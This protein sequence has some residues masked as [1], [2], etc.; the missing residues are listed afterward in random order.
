MIVE[1]LL[2]ILTILEFPDERLRKKAAPVETVDADIRKLVDDMFE[3]MYEA[4]GVGLAATQVNV[5][6]RVIVIDVSE[7]KKSPLCLINPEILAK[8]GIEETEEGCLSVPGFF[9]TVKRA[10]HIKVRA[11]NRDGESFEFE[12]EDLLA[13]CVQHE[14]DHLEGKLFVDYISP[15]KRQMIKKK[16]NKIH[17]LEQKAS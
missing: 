14:M 8:D 16:L 4:R 2:S 15:L 7:E 12:A 9:E 1:K 13:V 3:T 11:L 17:R 6:K 10:E 5:H